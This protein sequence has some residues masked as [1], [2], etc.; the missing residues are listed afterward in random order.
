M[1]KGV[2]RP[3]EHS[4]ERGGA[5]LGT[6]WER[7]GADHGAQWGAGWGG[8]EGHGGSK[9]ERPV[10]QWEMGVGTYPHAA[11]SVRAAFRSFLAVSVDSVVVLT[12]VP[13]TLLGSWMNELCF[14]AC[15]SFAWGHGSQRTQP[16][17]EIAG[18][19]RR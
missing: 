7:M 18:S 13:A 11:R 3:R 14:T 2:E 17:G 6:Q 8:P 15:C 12:V 4:G 10:E 16:P 19:R 1:G 5:T 9:C